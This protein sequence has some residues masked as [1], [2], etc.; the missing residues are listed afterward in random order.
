MATI[1]INIKNL[2]L[3]GR[4]EERV[5]PNMNRSM[6]VSALIQKGFAYEELMKNTV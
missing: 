4:I 2:S 6:I 3:L 1:S 5:T